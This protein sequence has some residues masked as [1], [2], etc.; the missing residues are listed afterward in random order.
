MCVRWPYD[1]FEREMIHN[2]GHTH[3]ARCVTLV[4][5][6]FYNARSVIWMIVKKKKIKIYNVAAHDLRSTLVQKLIA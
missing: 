1:W 6:H 4:M 3:A 5:L 2:V